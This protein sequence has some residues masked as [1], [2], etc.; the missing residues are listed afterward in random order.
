MTHIVTGARF[1]KF[2]LSA[3]GDADGLEVE[4]SEAETT[5]LQFED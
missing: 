1:V 3:S 4:N 2:T 5:V